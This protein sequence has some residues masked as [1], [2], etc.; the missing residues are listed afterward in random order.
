[1]LR[2]KMVHS[3]CLTEPGILNLERGRLSVS[4]PEK[5]DRVG[6]TDHVVVG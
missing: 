6:W 5:V 4:L 2:D 1:M 3:F